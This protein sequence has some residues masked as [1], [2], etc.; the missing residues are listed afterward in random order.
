MRPSIEA[1]FPGLMH[2]QWEVTSPTDV[3][4]N[5]IAWAAGDSSRWWWPSPRYYWPPGIRRELTIPAFEDLFVRFGF[6]P[7]EDSETEPTSAA[8][9]IALFALGDTPTHAAR[10]LPDGQW[11]SKLG[12]AIDISHSALRALEGQK[13]GAVVATYCREIVTDPAPVPI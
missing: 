7:C 10:R 12:T 1:A 9:R 6:V 13:Y 8:E 4:Y 11:T 5:C 3:R 2:A